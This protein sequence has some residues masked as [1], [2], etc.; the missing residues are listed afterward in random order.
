MIYPLELFVTLCCWFAVSVPVP[1]AVKKPETKTRP[2]TGTTEKSSPLTRPTT[3]TTEKSSPL[4]RPT[5]SPTST[6]ELQGGSR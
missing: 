6:A 2:T 1:V 4:T 5:A 3:G